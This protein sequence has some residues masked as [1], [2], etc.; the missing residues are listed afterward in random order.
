[1]NNHSDTILLK[2]LEEIH[3]RSQLGLWLLVSLKS[4]PIHVSQI[5]NYFTEHYP[6]MNVDSK[7]IYRTLR[8]FSDAGVVSYTLQTSPSGPDYKVYGLTEK[9]DRLLTKFLNIH[10]MPVY[11][12]QHIE[13]LIKDACT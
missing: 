13:H 10:V 3:K 5:K 4:S 9:G 8:R 7:S 11:Y 2:D 6:A 12:S 1:M